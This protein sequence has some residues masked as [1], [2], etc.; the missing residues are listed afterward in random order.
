MNTHL[1]I[2]SPLSAAIL[3]SSIFAVNVQ[4]AIVR[5][6]FSGN[7]SS[8]NWNPDGTNAAGP[9]GPVSGYFAID[10]DSQTVA[11]MLINTEF[12]SY[13][14]NQLVMAATYNLG[15]TDMDDDIPGSNPS[16]V[17]NISRPTL[18]TNVPLFTDLTGTIDLDGAGPLGTGSRIAI[19][20]A[21]RANTFG[22]RGFRPRLSIFMEGVGFSSMDAAPESINMGLVEDVWN[23]NIGNGNGGFSGSQNFTTFTATM[24]PEPSAA[25]LLGLGAI[26]LVARRQRKAD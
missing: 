18:A 5:Y 21:V 11:E 9:G 23:V 19:L 16:T 4:A 3:L 1:K 7:F 10:T 12:Y 15:V 6:N 24:V 8:S 26:G 14:N 25:L 13:Y 2:K 17:V 20:D 22:P